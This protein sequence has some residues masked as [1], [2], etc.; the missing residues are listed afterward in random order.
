MNEIG[1]MVQKTWVELPTHY[2]GVDIDEFAIMPNHLHGIIILTVGAGPRA[3]PEE[4]GQPQGVA[5]TT[6]LSLPDVM[7][8]FKSLTTRRY[9][10]GVKQNNWEPFK[11]HFWQRNYY[12]HVI[13]NE[14]D[15]NQIREYVITN[16]LKWAMDSENPNNC[17]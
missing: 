3:C 13:R 14:E 8:R 9:I 2:V 5:P 16:P 1:Q 17:L 15:L 4:K 11:K 7:H 6:I 12:E 10:E